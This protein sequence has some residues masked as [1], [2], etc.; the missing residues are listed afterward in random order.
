MIVAFLT[1]AILLGSINTV[2]AISK[3]VQMFEVFGV[4]FGGIFWVFRYYWRIVTLVAII[5]TYDSWLRI[6]ACLPV[7]SCFVYEFHLLFRVP[8]EVL[9]VPEPRSQSLP[10][11]VLFCVVP[12]I[13]LLAI[14]KWGI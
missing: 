13:Q 12:V 7:I 5:A 14:V 2:L 1:T 9:E 3:R 8:R 10:K 4:P 11:V 6:P